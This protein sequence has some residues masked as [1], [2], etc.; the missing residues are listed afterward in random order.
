MTF[1]F[2]ILATTID[3][4]E[5]HAI[6]DIHY[7]FLTGDKVPKK[8]EERITKNTDI[9]TYTLLDCEEKAKQIYHQLKD[10]FVSLEY[11]F[12]SYEKN[13]FKVWITDTKGKLVERHPWFGPS[14]DTD[15]EIK[16]LDNEN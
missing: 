9:E 12:R 10:D 14:F 8:R 11:R 3:E 2:P 13:R 4:L 6:C 1:S 7:Q 5:N 16:I 15:F